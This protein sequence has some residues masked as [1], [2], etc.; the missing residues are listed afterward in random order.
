MSF[1]FDDLGRTIEDV[2]SELARLVAR[3]DDEAT[4]YSA[5]RRAQVRYDYDAYAHLAR[6]AEWD[7]IGDDGA[8][9]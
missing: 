9:S 7:S 5:V 4:P 2:S 8:A 1:A 3:Y 6:I